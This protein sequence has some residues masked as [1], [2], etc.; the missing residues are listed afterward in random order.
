M[1]QNARVSFRVRLL[2]MILIPF[3]TISAILIIVSVVNVENVGVSGIQS[4][5]ESFVEATNERYN[6]LNGEPFS[7]VDGVMMKGDVEITGNYEVIDRLKEE[8]DIDTTV[9][10]GDT[11]VSTTLL[12][13]DGTRNIGTTAD[14]EVVELV[15]NQGQIV[16][17]DKLTINGV[18]YS[19]VYMPLTQ[20]DDGKIIGMLFAGIPRAHVQS[21]LN[22]T[23]IMVVIIGVIGVLLTVIINIFLANRMNAP[24]VHSAREMNKIAKGILDYKENRQHESRTDEIG[25]VARAAK[26][27]SVSLTQI[28]QDI[29]KTSSDLHS[30]SDRFSQSF[31]IMNDHLSN[32]DT[33]V[34]EI[35]NGATSQAEETQNANSGVVDIGNA[36]DDTVSNVEIL[37]SSTVKMREYNQSVH[38]TLDELSSINEKTKNS[39]GV[40]YKQTTA[41]NVS[42]NEI[43]S[44]TD[45]I[46]EIASQT[47]LLSL[48]A[49]IEAA[50][51]GDMGKGFAVVADEIRTLSEQSRESAE[52]IGTIINDL[53][54]NSNLSVE[55]MNEMTE[56]MEKQ[57]AMIDSTKELFGSLNFEIENVSQAVEGISR[58]TEVLE[59]IKDRVLGIVESLAAIAEENA[60][61]AEE[62]SASMTELEQMV[63][64]CKEVTKGMGEISDRL[65]EDTKIFSFK[66]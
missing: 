16:H 15:L 58:Q 17:K 51:A 2:M 25:D 66:E 6:A 42:A 37:G 1:E 20:P 7:M 3:I 63:A 62:T 19:C 34:G 23:I 40:V 30:F 4:Q 55:T 52:K 10:F 26:T 29:L 14:A 28:V 45:M 22:K 24:L 61:S 57:N 56:I 41:T 64:E 47:N 21:Q 50:R 53:L 31:V 39:V 18:S 12:N 46:T 38:N 33:A 59:E 36:I 43:R 27:L 35:A 65:K 48:N 11:R 44:A 9:F 49:S 54:E 60:A 13:E 5:L 32:I 8:T